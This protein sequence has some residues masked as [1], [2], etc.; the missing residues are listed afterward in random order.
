VVCVY[1]KKERKVE[2]YDVAAVCFFLLF[3][4]GLLVLSFDFF[5]YLAAVKKTKTTGLHTY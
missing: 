2:I 1:N 5:I 4:C 3:L